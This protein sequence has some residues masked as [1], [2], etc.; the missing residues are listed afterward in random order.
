M[1]KNISLNATIC[2][3]DHCSYG[4]NAF[5]GSSC[6]GSYQQHTC[7]VGVSNGSSR[8]R[9]ARKSRHLRLWLSRY[10]W[11]SHTS[12]PKKLGSTNQNSQT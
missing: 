11:S 4:S 2:P 5:Y 12:A 1:K 6:L 8:S 7:S 10:S 9:A 3:S